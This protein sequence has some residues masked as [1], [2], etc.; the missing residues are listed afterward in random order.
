MGRGDHD[1]ELFSCIEPR[2]IQC[3]GTRGQTVYEV[4]KSFGSAQR[5]W[6]G[7]GLDGH[8]SELP[9]MAVTLGRA[10]QAS[11]LVCTAGPQAGPV[12]LR[13]GPVP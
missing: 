9:P 1:L 11:G 5:S 4:G 12:G 13:L 2:G 10:G 6:C 8:R 7:K 3:Q